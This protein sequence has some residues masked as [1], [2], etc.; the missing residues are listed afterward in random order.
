MTEDLV[1]K[2]KSQGFEMFP[3]SAVAQRTLSLA[4]E[5]EALKREHQAFVEEQK[6]MNGYI[7]GDIWALNRKL[8]FA[9]K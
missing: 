6:K 8:R 9:E 3:V 7:K 1:K 5:L 2:F 4:E